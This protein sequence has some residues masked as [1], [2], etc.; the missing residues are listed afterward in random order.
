MGFNLKKRL[1]LITV[2]ISLATVTYATLQASGPV[3]KDPAKPVDE[4][5]NDD[6]LEGARE[7]VG[8]RDPPI[9]KVFHSSPG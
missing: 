4:S 9:E 2:C 1:L 7:G 6:D 5:R 8:N 3:Y